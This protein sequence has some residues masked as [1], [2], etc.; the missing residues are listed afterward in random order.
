MYTPK[1]VFG[2]FSTYHPITVFIYIVVIIIIAIMLIHPVC[3]C[4][5]IVAAVYY[6]LSAKGYND[7]S[8]VF[9]FALPVIALFALIN[10]LVNHRGETFLFYLNNNPI[11][12]ESFAAGLCAGIM[13]VSIMLWFVSFNHAMTSDK[14]L[15]LFGRLSPAA[16][17]ISSM[18]IRLVPQLKNKTMVIAN[19]QKTIGRDISTGSLICR[20]KNGVKIFSILITWSLENSIETADSMNARGYGNKNRGSFSPFMFEKKDAAAITVILV[21]FVILVLLSIKGYAMFSFFPVI[22]SSAPIQIMPVAFIY[23]LLCFIPK[24]FNTAELIYWKFS[25]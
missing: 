10:P 11:T 8:F 23:I 5:S 22:Q 18:T 25:K 9:K 14:F 7:T 3:L 19:A 24:I 1:A 20:F 12:L 17:L 15:F 6:A 16:A 21:C 4:V 13:L 2:I